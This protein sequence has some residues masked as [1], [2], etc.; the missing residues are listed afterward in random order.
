[1]LVRNFPYIDAEVRFA[2]R[3]YACTI[4]DI[5]SRRTRLAFLDRDAALSAI[6]RVGE[7]MAEELGWSETVKKEQMLAAREYVSSY[8]G[9][10]ID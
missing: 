3:E 7:I 4:E 5:L 8:A 1:M 9:R 10:T 6:P 2:C